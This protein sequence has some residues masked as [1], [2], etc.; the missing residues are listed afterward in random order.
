LN[1]IL[2]LSFHEQT[3]KS[4]HQTMKLSP[5]ALATALTLGNTVTEAQQQLGA[6]ASQYKKL[7]QLRGVNPSS[8]NSPKLPKDEVPDDNIDPKLL[9]LCHSIPDIDG[10]HAN[11]LCTWC[12]CGALPSSCFSKQSA[13]FLPPKVYTCDMN[14]EKP[15]EKRQEMIADKVDQSWK[16]TAEKATKV[17]SFLMDGVELNLSSDEVAADFCDAASPLSLAGYMNGE[18]F[19]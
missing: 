9:A 1:V 19:S 5:L 12:N 16:T 7:S 15:E 18:L 13:P 17:Q 2:I 4:N 10:C 3:V 6:V 8:N 11:E 14:N